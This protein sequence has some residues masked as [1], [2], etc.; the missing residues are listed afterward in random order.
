M[1]D[2]SQRCLRCMTL[3][4]LLPV[5]YY[6]LVL[7]LHP[8]VRRV[9]LLQSDLIVLSLIEPVLNLLG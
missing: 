4:F 8:I 3:D 9:Q 1:L 2:M 5:S 6:C 7:P